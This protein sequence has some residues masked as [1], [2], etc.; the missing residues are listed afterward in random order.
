MSEPSNRTAT[1][2]RTLTPVEDALQG[3]T[4]GAYRF[5]SNSVSLVELSHRFARLEEFVDDARARGASETE[6]QAAIDFGVFH[7]EVSA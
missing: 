1:A 3:V 2:R 7:R 5:A 6:I 4:V